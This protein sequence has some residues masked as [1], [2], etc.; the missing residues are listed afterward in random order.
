[1]SFV[2]WDINQNDTS[3]IDKVPPGMNP[4]E[5]LEDT[6]IAGEPVP[7]KIQAVESTKGFLQQIKS[8]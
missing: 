8:W 6:A 2:V 3:D 5:N 4:Y 1:M 7:T